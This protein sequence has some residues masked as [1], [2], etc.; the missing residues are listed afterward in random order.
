[1]IGGDFSEKTKIHNRDPLFN[2]IIEKYAKSD[3]NENGEKLIELCK[4]KVK[5]NLSEMNL[6]WL[7]VRNLAIENYNDWV[8]TIKR[9]FDI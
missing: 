3:I 7:E 2:K 4:I 8:R 5:E 6:S 9:Y 1:M